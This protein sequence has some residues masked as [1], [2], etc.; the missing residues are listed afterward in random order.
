LETQ[1]PYELKDELPKPEEIEELSRKLDL[2]NIFLIKPASTVDKI[3]NDL[4]N[5]FKNKRINRTLFSNEFSWTSISL[6]STRNM[7]LH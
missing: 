1:Y 5:G 4:T 7:D 2:H 6:V 3:L